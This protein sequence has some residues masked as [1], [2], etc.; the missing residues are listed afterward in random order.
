MEADDAADRILP[1]VL[2]FACISR[3]RAIDHQT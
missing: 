2:G 3:T 1:G